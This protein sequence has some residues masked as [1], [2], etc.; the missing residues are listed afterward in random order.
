MNGVQTPAPPRFAT[1]ARAQ[2][3]A[4]FSWA[5]PFLG[6][7]VEILIVL[8]DPV[9][10]LGIG[11]Q[12]PPKRNTPRLGVRLRVVDRDLQVHPSEVHAPEALDD[13]QRV[14]VRM[15]GVVQPRL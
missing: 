14:A 7:D 2:R 15:T 9:K 11:H 10:Q 1:R 4:T 8:T 12:L 13:M 6:K 3:H 5:S